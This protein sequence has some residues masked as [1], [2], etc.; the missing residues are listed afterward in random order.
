[1][2]KNPNDYWFV[3]TRNTSS[4]LTWIGTNTR[5]LFYT[6]RMYILTR[7]L[8]QTEFERKTAWCIQNGQWSNSNTNLGTSRNRVRWVN[9]LVSA[10]NETNNLLVLIKWSWSFV[11]LPIGSWR[12]RGQPPWQT[13]SEKSFGVGT[14][15]FCVCMY[16]PSK[17][18]A[19]RFTR[20]SSWRKSREQYTNKTQIVTGLPNGV[21]N[22][23]RKITHADWYSNLMV[24]ME[25]PHCSDCTHTHKCVFAHMDTFGAQQNEHQP[26][27][28]CN[29]SV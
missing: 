26:I 18:R 15:S 5:W 12:S 20:V 22:Q 23:N 7:A 6:I 16:R 3:F 8:W 29:E 19:S 1:M 24:P 2:C 4:K 11:D 10:L 28:F 25:A 13:M 9:V 17:R 14:M 21:W 27:F